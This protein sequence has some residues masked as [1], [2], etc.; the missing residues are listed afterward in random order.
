MSYMFYGCFSLDNLNLYNFKT[1]NVK[2]MN[3]MF[4]GCSLL[5]KLDISN[6]NVSKETNMSLILTGCNSLEEIYISKSI[7]DNP[8]N[9]LDNFFEGLDSKNKEK[10]LIIVKK[11]YK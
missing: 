1:N 9:I 6:F 11:N 7:Y 10:I 3:D 2:E 5:K 8:N 4:D